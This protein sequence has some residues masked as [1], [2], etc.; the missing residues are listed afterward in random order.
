MHNLI[1]TFFSLVK[2][3]WWRGILFS[4]YAFY[5]YINLLDNDKIASEYLFHQEVG[6]INL[7]G[8]LRLKLKDQKYLYIV[9]RQ[10]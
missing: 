10:I 6:V 2:G 9:T 5:K 7:Y 3:E 4:E 1:K 8:H